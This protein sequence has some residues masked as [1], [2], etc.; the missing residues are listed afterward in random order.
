M[1]GVL[2]FERSEERTHQLMYKDYNEFTSEMVSRSSRLLVV[3]SILVVFSRM[4][5]YVDGDSCERRCTCPHSSSACRCSN[6]KVVH[7]CFVRAVSLADALLRNAAARASLVQETEDVSTSNDQISSHPTVV[8][9]V[10]HRRQ[11]WISVV[12]SMS[13]VLQRAVS[14]VPP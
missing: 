14:V 8:A 1:S 13:L 10:T 5:V 2:R 4:R 11:M 12:H 6:S 7:R 3:V 9:N